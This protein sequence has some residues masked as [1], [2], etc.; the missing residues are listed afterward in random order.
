MSGAE[1]NWADFFAMGGKAL[2][3]WGSYGMV[4]FIA[5]V[6]ILLVRHRRSSTVEQ[7]RLMTHAEDS[8]D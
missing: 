7:L 6:E 2:Y 5:V 1:F 3:V 8:E 4:V